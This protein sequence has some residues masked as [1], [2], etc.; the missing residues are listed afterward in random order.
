MVV[1]QEMEFGMPDLPGVNNHVQKFFFVPDRKAEPRVVTM[2][3][4]GSLRLYD[5]IKSNPSDFKE[6]LNIEDEVF[7]NG[8]MSVA[9]D[10]QWPQSPY[11]YIYY[12]GYTEISNDAAYLNT[13]LGGERPLEW[14]TA[15]GCRPMPDLSNYQ[16]TADT[17]PSYRNNPGGCDVLS[18]NC[19]MFSR[20]DRVKLDVDTF[21]VQFRGHV[22]GSTLACG[23]YWG[24]HWSNILFL[25]DE[26]MV[27]GMGDHAID[28]IR[29]DPGNPL[30]DMCYSSDAGAPQGHWNPQR[31]WTDL[32]KFLRILP[33]KYRTATKPVTRGDDYEIIAK[34]VRNPYA[35]QVLPDDTVWFG[36]V[37]NALSER[38]YRFNARQAAGAKGGATLSPDAVN[39][40]WPCVEGDAGGPML[41]PGSETE[42][43]QYLRDEG[44]SLCDPVYKAAGINSKWFVGSPSN[45]K[46]DARYE[47]PAFEFR[48]V[49][50]PD[51]D[52]CRGSRAAVSG[53]YYNMGDK[54]G[55]RFQN[56][57]FF[58]DHEKQCLFYGSV[59]ENGK[60]V[61][62]RS[63]MEKGDVGISQITT[64]PTTGAL[65]LMDYQRS[66]IISITT[67]T[68]GPAPD[69]PPPDGGGKPSL[70][71]PKGAVVAKFKPQCAL[72]GE[73]RNFPELK[74]TQ[75][76][77]GVFRA[78]LTLG[79][80]QFANKWGTTRT[81]GYNG[82]VPAPLM[83]LRACG[84]YKLTLRNAQ[85]KWGNPGGAL[86][87]FREPATTNLH[88]HG[89]HVSGI[90]NADDTYREVLPGKETVYTYAIPCDHA[91][92]TH[93]YHP[94]HHGSVFLS[95]GAGAV[96]MLRVDDNPTLEA[97]TRRPAIYGRMPQRYL[98]FQFFDPPRLK[99]LAEGMGDQLFYT[100][101][102]RK[103]YLTN[104]CTGYSNSI[105][106]GKW[107][108]LRMLHIG[109]GA[110]AVVS[111]VREGGGKTCKVA[112][113]AKDGIYSDP[114]G[115]V[116][117]AQFYF[118]VSSR[119][120]V[121]VYCAQPGTYSLALK[122]AHFPKPVRLARFTVAPGKA[123][124][125]AKLPLW[126]PC[127]PF[128]LSDLRGLPAPPRTVA[129]SFANGAINGQL[130]A[131]A[132]TPPLAT[133]A[134]G[135]LNAW[136]VTGTDEHPF[137]LHVNPMQL[138]AAVARPGAP[139]GW[140]RAGDWLDTLSSPNTVNV[141][142]RT[143]RFG[144]NMIFHCHI[145]EHR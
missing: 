98:A 141:R 19:E 5:S 133:A 105:T 65:L 58:A 45:T 59:D 120:D 125:S 28:T 106:I 103:H 34:G 62:V 79:A 87:D 33:G 42:K 66:R 75:G 89:L 31:E 111:L 130:W 76:K 56:K 2:V 109:H 14:E 77:D 41:A 37:G 57:I 131:G 23:G 143:D 96:G 70:R 6:F 100:T 116:V 4:S 117:P 119:V 129:V 132:R 73:E 20:I 7:W 127:R 1:R 107:T 48:D 138:Q 97:N 51:F 52:G 121:A 136:S 108:R 81:R 30:G 114:A 67:K 82:G 145:Y 8:L 40:G 54:L 21:K 124:N 83:R 110:D 102:K 55:G 123:V 86:N 39:F 93:F 22:Y 112:M 68:D 69:T 38:I 10:P 18:W 60:I 49:V 35:V 63:L 17:C 80:V 72:Q 61:N 15:G 64:H 13:K 104:G 24:H 101:A 44:F 43:A 11:I 140:F 53:V 126:K 74:W 113:L 50:D 115:R 12:I 91:G 26:S 88:T 139:A 118:S 122:N 137:H 78:T 99:A 16:H 135:A 128:Y 84:V 32:G 71:P 142:F 29:V 3:S 134:E 47:S 9:F 144:G 94:H 92:G 36:D 85:Q 95:A 46:A 27:F 90:G 25:S